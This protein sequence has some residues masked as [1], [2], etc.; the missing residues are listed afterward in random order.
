MGFTL[1]LQTG[2]RPRPFY[3][4]R[5]GTLRAVE[6]PALERRSTD[7]RSDIRFSSTVLSPRRQ[8]LPS[9][10]DVPDNTLFFEA[11][12]RESR[13]TPLLYL[14]QTISRAPPSARPA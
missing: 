5:S 6:K 14:P 9:P 7:S 4:V 10:E 1:P 8:S 13:K 12:L 3:S 2:Q 11:I